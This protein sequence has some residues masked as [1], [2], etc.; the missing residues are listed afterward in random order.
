[1]AERSQHIEN[2]RAFPLSNHLIY[3][4]KTSLEGDGNDIPVEVPVEGSKDKGNGF[5][6]DFGEGEDADFSEIEKRSPNNDDN[7]E[8]DNVGMG[9]DGENLK[10]FNFESKDAAE[11]TFD[12]AGPVQVNDADTSDTSAA[13]DDSA[14]AETQISE[15]SSETVAKAE[16]PTMSP[17][18]IEDDSITQVP[19][20]K[21][22]AGR[23]PT[24]VASSA[25]APSANDPVY[26]TKE[27]REGDTVEL[28]VVEKKRDAIGKRGTIVAILAKKGKVKID[29]DDGK[30]GRVSEN[31]KRQNH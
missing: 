15:K 25:E 26:S 16:I 18:P 8:D 9:M 13:I 5:G 23:S 17:R 24:A 1:M 19:T 14:E 29:F 30:E 12:A 20:E 6:N 2:S 3:V 4:M 22:V 21:F 7:F 28:V 27:F 31:D 11:S 10:D